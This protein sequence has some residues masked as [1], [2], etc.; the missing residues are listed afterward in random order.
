MTDW[1]TIAPWIVLPSLNI[2]FARF[3]D[4]PLLVAKLLLSRWVSFVDFTITHNDA[5]FPLLL[6]FLCKHCVCTNKQYIG[7]D[8]MPSGLCISKYGIVYVQ[9]VESMSGFTTADNARTQVWMYMVKS[10]WI[11]IREQMNLTRIGGS[12]HNNSAG[13][14]INHFAKDRY[15]SFKGRPSVIDSAR[16]PTVEQARV[17]SQI[18]AAYR[19]FNRVIVFVSGPP[20]TGK[21]T[22]GLLLAREMTAH[23]TDEFDPCGR[24][25]DFNALYAM[26]NPGY[27]KPLVVCIEEADTMIKDVFVPDPTRHPMSGMMDEDRL[28]RNKR[29]YN[30]WIDRI[31]NR[32]PYV[33]LLLT[34]N[35]PKEFVDSIDRCVLAPHRVHV[36]AE[37]SVSLLEFDDSQD[38]SSSASVDPSGAHP[39]EQCEEAKEETDGGTSEALPCSDVSQGK[40]PRRVLRMHCVIYG[41]MFS[42]PQ[43]SSIHNAQFC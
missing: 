32:F 9:H 38:I 37:L 31:Q 17:I 35:R 42:L 8:E 14:V 18:A 2:L 40:K 19:Q 12:S 7:R 3:Q 33:I 20:C 23:Y 16:V 43:R 22:L 24:G 25:H 29:T 27:A 15:G 21:T 1:N 6:Q 30:M 5:A 34:S 39:S 26:A 11:Y 36:C 4:A 28:V 10:R 13:A 41:A